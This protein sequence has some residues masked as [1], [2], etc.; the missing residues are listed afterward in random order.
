MTKRLPELRDDGTLDTVISCPYCGEE[1]RYTYQTCDDDA[2]DYDD[3]VQQCLD[4][5]DEDHEC[6]DHGYEE[7]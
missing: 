2:T 1:L 6:D 4:D 7:E 5:F 3:F